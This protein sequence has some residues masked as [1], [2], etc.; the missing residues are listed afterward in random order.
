MLSLRKNTLRWV[1]GSET[2]INLH[3]NILVLQSRLVLW[4]IFLLADLTWW[5]RTH[6][7]AFDRISESL[8]K[9]S[10][11]KRSSW[12]ACFFFFFYRLLFLKSGTQS[13]V[14]P[15]LFKRVD[16][17]TVIFLTSLINGPSCLFICVLETLRCQRKSTQ[18][19]VD[20]PRFCKS[21][22]N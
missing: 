20:F 10:T 7:E 21:W 6:H 22:K 13:K 17:M 19:P 15:H 8:M 9:M 16:I 5:Q 11:R 2:S 18:S 1:T 3:G 12:W 4:R 14:C